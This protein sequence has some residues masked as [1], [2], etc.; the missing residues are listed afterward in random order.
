MS[1]C[2]RKAETYQP[3]D[4]SE[5]SLLTHPISDYGSDGPIKVS[6][7]DHVS[8]LAKSWI[9]ALTSLGLEVNSSPLGGNNLGAS[10]HAASVDSL[11]QTRSYSTSYLQGTEGRTNLKI[12]T[13]CT[14][15]RVILS[16]E[17]DEDGNLK[18]ESVEYRN[19]AQGSTVVKARREI[20]LCAGT[21][22]TPAILERS[23]IGNPS[24][25]KG[26]GIECLVD[27][28]GVGENLQDVSF[29][30]HFFT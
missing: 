26:T 21:I 27:Q 9:P 13:E 4:R 8:Q 24:I 2:M 29:E 30:V 25:L 16:R 12:M 10:T 17:K 22:E 7:S 15:N 18:V 28:P 14:V 5:S 6:F 23:G 1:L 3:I 20:M 11:D 19:Q